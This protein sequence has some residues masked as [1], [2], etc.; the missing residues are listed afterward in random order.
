MARRVRMLAALVLL[1]GLAACAP[2]TPPR[3]SVNVISDKFSPSVTLEGLPLVTR[4]SGNQV[5][6]MLRS[7][8]FVQTHSAEQQIYVEWF[9]PGHGTSRYMAA[10]DTAR[11]LRVRPI[12][13]ENC[14]R[15]C[16]QTDTLGIDIDEATLRARVATGLQVKLSDQ[17]NNYVVL[18][19]T[20]AMIAAQLQTEDR[21]FAGPAGAPP[22]A[23]V[24][25]TG[26]PLLGIAPFD[27]PF[28][29]G[30][31]VTRVDP[32]TPA[33]AAGFQVGDLVQSYNGQAVTG[34][35]QLRGLIGQTRPGSVVPIEV[36]RH[37]QPMTLSA[38]M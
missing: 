14:G 4:F 3:T 2:S 6:W 38:Q 1:S 22:V 30:V 20:P 29:V 33:A 24:T 36:K 27:L 26:Q 15:E 18:D 37:G 8:V 28:G 10:D 32:N 31:T 12:L 13:K 11:A 5:F 21:V 34:A 25:A 9:F 7:F 23:S 19:I 16:G 17:A 35:D